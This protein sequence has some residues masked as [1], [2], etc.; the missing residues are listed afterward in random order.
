MPEEG[1]LVKLLSAMKSWKTSMKDKLSVSCE[2]WD[3]LLY[4]QQ[5]VA[6]IIAN[7]ST[8]E[9]TLK[10]HFDFGVQQATYDWIV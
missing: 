4:N 8:K 3:N 10:H 6:L 9:W 1:V 7:R 2:F 5:V